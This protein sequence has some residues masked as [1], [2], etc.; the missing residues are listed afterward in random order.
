MRR[1]EDPHLI[2]GRG[3][4]A[5]DIHLP[6]QAHLVVVR[7][8]QP[9]AR[10]NGIDVD[11]ARAR[12]GVLA[13]W[14]AGDLPEE[15]RVIRDFT[16]RGLTARPRPVLAEGEVNYVG[17]ALAIVVAETPYQAADAAEAVFADLEPLPAAG[18]V[19]AALAAGAPLVHADLPDNSMG[20]YERA[21]GDV[22]AAF[23][24]GAVVVR[25]SLRLARI[26]GAAMEPRAVTAQSDGGHLRVWTST[27]HT[28]GV[29]D[30]LSELLKLDKAQIEVLAE[31][32][33]GGF[34]PKAQVY[35]EEILTAWAAMTLKRPVRWVATRSEDTSTTVH[36]HGTVF[37]VEIAGDLDG[38]LRGLR[39]HLWH[40]VGAYP[41]SGPNQPGLMVA[42]MLSAY[43]VPAMH[44]RVN[45]VHTN[46][47]STGFVRGGGRPAGNFVVERMMDR[48]ARRLGLDPAEIRRRNLV[49]PGE[50]PFDTGFPA[51][52][53]TVI[54]DSGDYPALLAA[55]MEGVGYAEVRRAQAEPADGA[56]LRGVGVACCVE[57][58][59]FGSEQA[60]VRVTRDGVATA[61]LGST[62]Q[63]Q[64]HLTA[65]AQVL[66]ERL[67]W[68]LERVHAVAGNTGAVEWGEMTAG[69]RTAVQVGNAVSM[70]AGSTRR[71]ILEH[72]AEKLE[73]DAGDLVLEDGVV[74]VKGSPASSISASEVV[75]EDGLEVVETF[76]PALPNAYS[77]GCHAAVVDVDP[78][79]GSVEIVR[80]AIVHDTGNPINPLLVQGQLQGGYVHGLGYALFEELIYQ[81]EG[82][83]QSASFL[84]YTM[85][86]APEVAVEPRLIP[87]GTP[88]PA[89]PEGFKGAGESGTIPV[90]AAI[91]NAIEDALRQVSPDV[92]INELP[93][94]PQR[95]FEALGGAT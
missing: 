71:W 84:D 70:A 2:T 45:L 3:R 65:A 32:V 23:G 74:S 20:G 79:T 14:T 75:P 64:G 22:D 55:A 52:R 19:G 42:H 62:P 82:G 72:A 31:D 51:G 61:F 87:M 25:E 28:F 92:V 56:R 93:I 94:T 11:G 68:P 88:T 21:F 50:M 30:R 59:G 57:S 29:R 60:R 83:F 10:I 66:A 38:R 49:Q 35:A 13:V 8:S 41:G 81:P 58:S 90:P 76:Q 37:E 27:Q 69:S 18:T 36:A 33:G 6:D 16:P 40:D 17:D 95:V 12:P 63:G 4:Y 46:T 86:S 15:A 73:A 1:R 91:A 5:G 24:D 34:G 47:A 80:Y 26:A 85:A 67:G 7:S 44:F 89:N 53:Q 43:R 48:L 39:G 9:H 77:S 54:Y 78:V